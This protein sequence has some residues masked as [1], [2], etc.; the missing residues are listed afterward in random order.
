MIEYNAKQLN[1]S[2]KKVIDKMVN[3][4]VMKINH[5]IDS[6]ASSIASELILKDKEEIRREIINKLKE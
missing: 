1:A 5:I 6:E 2:D 4:F 3:S